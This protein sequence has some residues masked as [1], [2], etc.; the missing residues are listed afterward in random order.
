[1]KQSL[2]ITQKNV[3]LI[4]KFYKDHTNFTPYI[5]RFYKKKLGIPLD[6]F[7]IGEKVLRPEKSWAAKYFSLFIYENR[8]MFKGKDVLDL[9]CGSG[10]QGILALKFGGVNSLVSS[11]ISKY[12][13]LCTK[14]NSI[15]LGLE[16]KKFKIVESDLFNKI[17]DKF[18][19]IIFNPPYLSE[20]PTTEID[21]IIKMKR[22]KFEKFFDDYSYYLKEGGKVFMAYSYFG[23]GGNNPAEE[24]NKRNINFNETKIEDDIGEHTMFI[25]ERK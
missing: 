19:F 10:I 9:G 1:M 11:D 17:N 5:T 15:L 23:I 7:F 21:Y 18:D 24:S 8:T 14:I 3:S 20:E 16:G 2:I 25:L 13:I 12:A 4:E 6:Y 22:S